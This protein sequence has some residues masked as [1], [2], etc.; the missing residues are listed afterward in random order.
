MLSIPK[1]YIELFF[2]IWILL[3]CPTSEILRAVAI[4]NPLVPVNRIS[5]LNHSPLGEAS[6]G[7]YTYSV[8]KA[9]WEWPIQEPSVKWEKQHVT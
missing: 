6:K 7:E 5:S 3:L 4:F 2:G 9:F 1:L 8:S